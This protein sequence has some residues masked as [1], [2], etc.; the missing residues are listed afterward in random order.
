MDKKLYTYFIATENDLAIGNDQSS[1]SPVRV[2][3]GGPM[4]DFMSLDILEIK[5]IA[6][7]LIESLKAPNE[8]ESDIPLDSDVNT[9]SS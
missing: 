3:M 1:P 4:E 7:N 6:E 2:L 9:Q 5:Q 8:N